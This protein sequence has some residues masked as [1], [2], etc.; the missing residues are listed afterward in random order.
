MMLK[1]IYNIINKET[2]CY[3][4][5]LNVFERELEFLIYFVIMNVHE[6]DD[7]SIY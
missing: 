7:G 1:I 4:L 6:K 2:N 3:Y 5:H